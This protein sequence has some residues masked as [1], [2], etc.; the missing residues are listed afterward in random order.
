MSSPLQGWNLDDDNIP[1]SV[2]QHE[3][4]LALAR[5]DPLSMTLTDSWP[6]E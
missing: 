3:R 2:T 1:I 4:T 6:N 5:Q